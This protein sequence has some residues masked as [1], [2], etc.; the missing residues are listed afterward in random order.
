MSTDTMK[1]LR[2]MIR[3]LS[4]EG[5]NKFRSKVEECLRQALDQGEEEDAG[6]LAFILGLLDGMRSGA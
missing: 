4:E 5:W 2:G 6:A 1:I 3:G